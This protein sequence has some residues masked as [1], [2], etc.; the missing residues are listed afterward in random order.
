MTSFFWFFGY[1]GILMRMP[2]AKSD[3]FEG[4][5]GGMGHGYRNV[6]DESYLRLLML[7]HWPSPT[8]DK[9]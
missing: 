2:S 4:V 9:R 7:K 3:G 8:R 5:H 6:K 1:V